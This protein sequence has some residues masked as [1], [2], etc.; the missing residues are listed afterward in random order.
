MSQYEEDIAEGLDQSINDERKA[1]NDYTERM[2]A[3]A[4]DTETAKV[5]AH[6]IKEEREHEKEFMERLMEVTEESG[7]K[8]VSESQLRCAAAGLKIAEEQSTFKPS[9]VTPVLFPRPSLYGHDALL[10]PD[11][12]L[13]TR[14]GSAGKQIVAMVLIGEDT[15]LVVH[16]DGRG[17]CGY[18]TGSQEDLLKPK[19]REKVLADNPYLKGS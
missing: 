3:G 7:A 13:A 6:V 1:I 8:D 15:A 10:V 5:Y 12:D 9:K 2:N 16:D 4:S 11:T 17:G 19:L 14:E 18:I